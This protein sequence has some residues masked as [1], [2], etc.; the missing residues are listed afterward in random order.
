MLPLDTYTKWMYTVELGT[1]DNMVISKDEL[2][3]V[4]SKEST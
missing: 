2:L 4:K 3:K 1:T